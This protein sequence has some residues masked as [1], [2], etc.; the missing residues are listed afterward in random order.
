MCILRR[1]S[2]SGL[3][4]PALNLQN[5]HSH[6]HYCPSA[7]VGCYIGISLARSYSMYPSSSRSRPWVS[8]RAFLVRP[9]YAACLALPSRL[10][11]HLY[12]ASRQGSLQQCDTVTVHQVRAMLD[13][14]LSD[15]GQPMAQWQ[16]ANAAVQAL[17]PQGP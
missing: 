1:C 17:I 10:N 5:S 6:L 16:Q 14:K 9:S 15:P 2:L 8:C 12:A 3:S 13:F 7:H 11:R 4:S